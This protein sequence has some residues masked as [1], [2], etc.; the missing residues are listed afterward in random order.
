MKLNYSNPAFAPFK[1]IFEKATIER[2]KGSY[3]QFLAEN[4]EGNDSVISNISISDTL[5][6]IFRNSSV[7]KTLA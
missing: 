6:Y 2:R 4:T 5:F 3:Y 7:F 1:E